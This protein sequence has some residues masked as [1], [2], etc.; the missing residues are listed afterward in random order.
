MTMNSNMILL[1]VLCSVLPLTGCSDST[2][3]ESESALSSIQKD[4]ER[5]KAE[6][7]CD[8]LAA[9]PYD[10]GRKAEG[11]EFNDIDAAAAIEA[12]RQAVRLNPAP[13]LQLQYGRSLQKEEQ[14]IEAVK[15]YRKAAE[16]GYASAKSA[17]GWMYANGRGVAKNEEEAVKWYRKAAEQGHANAQNNLGWMYDSG[18]GVAKNEEEAVKWYR[19]AAEQGYARAK[20]NLGWMYQN[21]HGV[22]KNE[23]E[24]VKW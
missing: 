17:L 2:S 9:S 5:G 12:C 18:Q 6:A 10:P 24:A 7:E 8:R 20:N 19:K 22:A 23:E 4:T 1:A 13:R 14:H 21:G 16:Q 15:W 11:V 3:A